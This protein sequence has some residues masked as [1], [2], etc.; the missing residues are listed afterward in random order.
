VDHGHHHDAR[1]ED[2]QDGDL[3]EI[4]GLKSGRDNGRQDDEVSGDVRRHDV[5]QADERA[6]INPAGDE[7]ERDHERAVHGGR[8]HTRWTK[9]STTR[10]SMPIRW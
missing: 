3:Q 8:G 1:E 7:G 10:F 2:R 4:G 9:L 6:G 5:V